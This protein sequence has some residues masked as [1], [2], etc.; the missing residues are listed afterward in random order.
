MIRINK[1]WYID[2]DRHGYILC[3]TV[4]AK[5]KKTGEEY[6]TDRQISFH[7]TVSAAMQYFMR[8]H[9]RKLT[10]ETDMTLKEAIDKFKEIE[11]LV[12]E[13]CNKNI[14]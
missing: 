12:L 10:E 2:A 14:I 8:L 3:K 4:K 9:H 6:M 7:P 1:K 13:T 5:N 11:S